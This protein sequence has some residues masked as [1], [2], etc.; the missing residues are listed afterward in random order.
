LTKHKKFAIIKLSKPQTKMTLNNKS[1]TEILRNSEL[2]TLISR[3]SLLRGFG[4]LA[5]MAALHEVARPVTTKIGEIYDTLASLE[6][7]LTP[8]AMVPLEPRDTDTPIVESQLRG[9]PIAVRTRYTR[10][11][12]TTVL[13]LDRDMS[14]RAEHTG[15]PIEDTQFTAAGT[16]IITTAEGLQN[17]KQAYC[18][19]FSSKSSKART[20]AV[21]YEGELYTYEPALGH[22]GSQG[23]WVRVVT[24]TSEDALPSHAVSA[25]SWEALV[26]AK[27]N[28]LLIE[29][30]TT[31]TETL[32]ALGYKPF[33]VILASTRM[34]Q[35]KES[36][37][38]PEDCAQTS[39]EII[40][41]TKPYF[42]TDGGVVVDL[43]HL[44]AKAGETL[45]LFVQLLSEQFSGETHPTATV[46]YSAGNDAPYTFA[47]E[48]TSLAPD[49]IIDTTFSV[50]NAVST[51]MEGVSQRYAIE[52]MPLLA[53]MSTRSGMS[54]EDMFTN[55]LGSS[56]MLALVKEY[57]LA[58]RLRQAL[59]TIHYRHPT[60][61]PEKVSSIV[62]EELKPQLVSHVLAQTA[63]TH[64]IRTFDTSI[65]ARLP[66]GIY[67]LV[68]VKIDSKDTASPTRITTLLRATGITTDNPNVRFTPTHVP[69][70]Q[71]TVGH[72]LA[73]VGL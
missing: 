37:F 55:A 39:Q 2:D 27:P 40:D 42:I 10:L 14:L 24:A 60:M 65:T 33:G 50:M 29:D 53:T 30:V 62:V 28:K 63:Q 17:G 72:V 26:S 51:L 71:S 7:L 68:P 58:E 66:R 3:R 32:R 8:R 16:A 12:E 59:Q 67:S 47:V 13:H 25:S 49:T 5:A 36:A 23:E 44:E 21:G 4:G 38:A 18:Q 9:E 54:H 22:E 6:T 34:P 52:K 48:P 20:V 56:G 64:G 19:L 15:D 31:G 69:A 1:M 43:R 46:R 70:I 73:E 11:D 57:G 41:H 61:S 35:E 45:S